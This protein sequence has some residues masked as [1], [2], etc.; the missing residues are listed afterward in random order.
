MTWDEA[1]DR[2]ATALKF[3]NRSAN[4]ITAYLSDLALAVEYWTQVRGRHGIVSDLSELT[5]DDVANWLF[6]LREVQ[7]LSRATVQRRQ[8]S[9]KLFL[10]YAVEQRWI[11]ASPYP[12]SN[13]I[14]AKETS[15]KRNIVYLESD[16][17][18]QFMR[19]VS[20]GLPNDPEWVQ[21]RDSALLWLMLATGLRISETC[22]LTMKDI[23]DGM[24]LGRLSVVG[25]G[26]KQRY[27]AL[28]T[29]THPSLKAYRTIRP[30][31]TL[32]AFFVTQRRVPKGQTFPIT[33]LMPREVRRRIEQYTVRSGL[34]MH[35]SPHKLRHTFAT[36]LLNTGADIR[37]VQEA[38]GHAHLATTEIYAH[39][40]AK[41]QQ[42]AAKRL[43][44]LPPQR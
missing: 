3:A 21:R 33:P 24:R 14:K 31:T 11:T 20:A 30:A 27:V 38:L 15:A 4:T 1:V 19:A 5:S 22:Q 42:D 43:P 13:V 18:T 41:T 16:Q 37:V 17:A 35:L 39:I 44:Y 12:E 36:N 40:N 26:N 28:P 34:P 2:F 10:A 6:T 8:A 29:A 32:D 25:K 7:E 9:L 23:A